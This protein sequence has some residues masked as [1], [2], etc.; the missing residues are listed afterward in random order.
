M[1]NRLP[2][3]G[4]D[5][6]QWGQILNDFLSVEHNGDGTLKRSLE[7]TGQLDTDGHA[8]SKAALDAETA[9]RTAAL[10]LKADMTDM[11]FDEIIKVYKRIPSDGSDV[12]TALQAL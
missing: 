5:R 9:A 11:R 12:T 7:V 1:A 10:T 3:P 8:A 4:S 6:N 2:T